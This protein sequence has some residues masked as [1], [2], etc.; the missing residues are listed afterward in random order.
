MPKRGHV[1]KPNA[2]SRVPLRMIWVD[3]EAANEHGVGGPGQ[4]R[5]TFG[6]ANYQSYSHAESPTPEHDEW[7]R[8]TTPESFWNWVDSKSEPGNTTWVLAHNWNY[9]AGILNTSKILPA[10]GWELGKYIN[11]KPPLIVRWR[12][13]S[14]VVSDEREGRTKDRAAGLLMVD[15]LNYFAGTAASLGASVGLAKLPMPKPEASREEWDTYCKRD[16]EVIRA[17]FL[18]LRALVRCA[19]LGTMQPTLAS[20]ALTAYR[21]RYMPT[22]ILIHDHQKALELER[23]AY[24]GGRTEAFWRGRVTEHLY[25]LDVNSMYPAIMQGAELPHWF[26]HY[27]EGGWEVHHEAW[28]LALEEKSIVAR[29]KIDTDQPCYGLVRDGKLIF[30]VGQ[31][32]TTLCTPEIK[33][34]LA[35]GHLKWVGEFAVY[36]KAV[37]FRDFVDYFHAKRQEY[38][39]AGNLAFTYMCKILMNSLYGKFGQ[40]GRRWEDT[41][42]HYWPYQEAGFSVDAKGNNIQL[43]QRMGQ[44]QILAR[45]A[46]S[47]NSF[48]LIAAEITALA[49]LQVWE[50]ITTAGEQNVFYTD[51]DS[52]VVNGD[53]YNNLAHLID[54]IQLGRLKL[55]AEADDAEFLAPKHYN[56]D[57][58]WTIKGVKANAVLVLSD[59]DVAELQATRDSLAADLAEALEVRESLTHTGGAMAP[60]FGTL[61]RADWEAA[62]QGKVGM[63]S[64][65]VTARARV[66]TLRGALKESDLRLKEAVNPRYKQV[67]FRSWDFNLSRGIDGEITVTPIIKSVSGINTKRVVTGPGWTQPI[68]LNE[69]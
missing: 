54:P 56:F 32:E 36:R 17:A 20:Q 4:Q 45:E 24:H 58:K 2:G 5:L 43:R 60:H 39:A 26:E 8:F 47:S 61:E 13:G 42:Q 40:S 57:G 69:V 30:P 22:Q 68:C 16:V 33:Y 59:N 18:A 14:G 25:K 15:T 64:R 11:G 63:E 52:L 34:A 67:V 29:C 12:K 31:F 53:G 35:H 3:C 23:E 49:R 7:C 55:E 10:L 46:E 1:L 37:L 19:D 21:H 28:L 50:L 48:P 44:T 51:T 6:W 38:R 66:S 27:Y 9:D 62:H 65:R 41:N